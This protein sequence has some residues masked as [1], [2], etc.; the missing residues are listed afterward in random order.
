MKRQTEKAEWLA[1]S[2]SDHRRISQT[3][4]VSP[5]EGI[6]GDSETTTRVRCF[7]AIHG[8]I[9]RLTGSGSLY[10]L[11][12]SL[13]PSYDQAEQRPKRQSKATRHHDISRPLVACAL[14][15]VAPPPGDRCAPN[16]MNDQPALTCWA[17]RVGSPCKAESTARRPIESSIWCGYQGICSSSSCHLQHSPCRADS[18]RPGPLRVPMATEVVLKRER[19]RMWT[20]CSSR[21]RTV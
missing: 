8:F 10:P 14:P 7:W 18:A 4:E 6:M 2:W 15:P 21:P 13:R 11:A 12:S 16:E 17:D 19:R 1:S 3:K 5:L 20:A 9:E